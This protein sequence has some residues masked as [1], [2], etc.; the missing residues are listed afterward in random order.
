MRV[1]FIVSSGRTGTQFLAHYLDA[2]YDD[3]VARHE[4]PPSR[5]LRL[6]SHARLDG[7]LSRSTLRRLLE[8]YRRR[9]LSRLDATLYVESNPFLA[10][11]ADVLDEV[12]EA[13]TLIH[14]VRDPRDYVRSAMNHGLGTGWKGLANR[15]LPY[16]YPKV[17]RALDLREP[18]DWPMRA[19]AHWSLVNAR[20]RDA[21]AGMEHYLCLHYEGIFDSERSGLRALCRALDLPF[22]DENDEREQLAVSP[23]QPINRA[24][25]DELPDW[26]EW[27]P[28]RCRSLQ[29]LCGA[30]M[31]S[32]GYGS[33]PEWQAKLASHG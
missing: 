5:L 33:E 16:W 7:A 30:Q 10:G 19:A 12:F 28:E 29:R 13:A 14:V 24:T 20:L 9:S 11:F 31:Q 23:A 18:L 3:V 15:W 26:R 17:E 4:P 27:T 2:N 22:R 25:L 8:R 6:A 1:A 21:G 32:Y